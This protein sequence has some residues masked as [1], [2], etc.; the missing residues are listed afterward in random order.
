[1][2]PELVCGGK[3]L[4]ALGALGS[5]EHA[6]RWLA[7]IYPKETVELGEEQFDVQAS[8]SV[9]NV[10]AAGAVHDARL[11]PKIPVQAAS[12]ESGTTD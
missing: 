3:A 5:D 2:M 9:V 12:L 1:M 11:D 4:L 7:Q 8:N 10:D 6:G